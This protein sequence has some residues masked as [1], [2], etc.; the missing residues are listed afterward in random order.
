[1]FSDLPNKRHSAAAP[2]RA[3]SGHPDHLNCSTEGRDISKW[4][5]NV[6]HREIFYVRVDSVHLKGIHAGIRARVHAGFD[7]RS[8]QEKQL[9]PDPDQ[10]DCNNSDC[11][12]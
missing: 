12:L 11:T 2:D 8:P 1:M 4:V 9:H 7:R 6:Q 10:D 3:R 5:L